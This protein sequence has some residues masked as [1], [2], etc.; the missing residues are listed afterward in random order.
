MAEVKSGIEGV[1]K[2]AW[3]QTGTTTVQSGSNIGYGKGISFD[4][5]ENPIHI[6]SGSSYA[7]SKKQRAMG[8]L[9]VSKLFVDNDFMAKLGTSTAS[10][11][12]GRHYVELHVDGIAGTLEDVYSFRN[13]ALESV[14]RTHPEEAESTEEWSFFF[15]YYAHLTAANKLIT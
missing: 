12:F 2:M 14:S 13:C 8:K 10:E 15:D 11:T 1:L 5:S 6:W 7:H 9:T 4:W 3:G